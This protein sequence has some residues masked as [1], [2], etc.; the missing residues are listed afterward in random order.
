MTKTLQEVVD[1]LT[2]MDDIFFHKLAEDEGFCEELLQVILENKSLKLLENKPQYVLKNIKGRSVVLDL[3][4]VDEGN[5]II[6]V[7]IQKRDDDDHV[8]RVRYNL[9]N[10]DTAESEKGIKFEELNDIY[11]IYI[12]KFDMFHKEKTIYHVD[13]VLRETK[14]IVDNGTHEIYVNTKIDDGTDIAE[15]MQLLKSAA[16]PDNLKFPRTCK[17]IRNVKTGTEDDGMCDLVEEYAKEYADEERIKLTV[18][19]YNDGSISSDVAARKLKITEEQF[20]RY[21]EK[22][23]E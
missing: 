1:Q 11:V 6:N 22:Y 14:D 5:R 17:A 20:M 2:A 23:T 4:C 19:F 8:R 12:S 15:Y 10:I 13:R 3:K 7:E 21:V 18:S 9:A 16:V